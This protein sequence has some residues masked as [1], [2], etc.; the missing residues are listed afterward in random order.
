[1]PRRFCHI[2]SL[3]LAGLLALAA[4]GCD[5]GS[6]D[7]GDEEPSDEELFVGVWTFASL[8]E[9][10]VDRSNLFATA[11]EAFELGFESDG[12]YRVDVDPLVGEP[13][14]I[15]G[16]YTVNEG[17]ETVSVEADGQSVTLD[18]GFRSDNDRLALTTDRGAELSTLLGAPG[19]LEGTVTFVVE[20]D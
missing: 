4:I 12:T 3:A 11:V 19:L 15:N 13:Q 17:E 2:A 20:R 9:D 8:T 16:T 5:S 14:E 1:M 6:D 7:N 10:G 18:Y